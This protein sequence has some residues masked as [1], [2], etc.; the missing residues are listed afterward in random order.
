MKENGA[1]KPPARIQSYQKTSK[2]R[3]KTTKRRLG[4]VPEEDLNI[5]NQKID[6]QVRCYYFSDPW[7]SK[8]PPQKARRIQ[9]G[10]ILVVLGDQN[11]NK[12]IGFGMRSKK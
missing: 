2:R 5:V 9:Y 6:N 10:G 1:K 4:G 3:S 7:K 8:G 12:N 11:R